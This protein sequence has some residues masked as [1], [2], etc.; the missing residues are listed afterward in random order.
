[1]T[2]NIPTTVQVL[3]PNASYNIEGLPMTSID[4]DGYAYV[5]VKVIIGSTDTAALQLLMQ[6]STDDSTWVPVAGLDFSVPP[7]SLPTSASSNTTW[8]F[9]IN[10]ENVD[11]YLLPAMTASSGDNGMY[12]TVIAELFPEPPQTTDPGAEQQ[13]TI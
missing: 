8:E 13:L 10:V 9:L 1:M 7:S 2:P 4:T 12:V 5:I 3:P 11:R 6:Q